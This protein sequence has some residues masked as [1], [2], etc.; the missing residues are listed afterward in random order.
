[1]TMRAQW[2]PFQR[3]LTPTAKPID[4]NLA[5]RAEG[6]PE[7]PASCSDRFRHRLM[8]P[9]AWSEGRNSHRSHVRPHTLAWCCGYLRLCP[10]L[11]FPKIIPRVFWV[12]KATAQAVTQGRCEYVLAM[13]FTCTGDRGGACRSGIGAFPDRSLPTEGSHQH[14]HQSRPPSVSSLSW[15]VP[16]SEM[17]EV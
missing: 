12:R 16:K 10:H 7:G 6:V 17:P 1:M 5:A 14:V 4:T 13:V 11:D 15:V 9:A 3:C 2:S 8:S